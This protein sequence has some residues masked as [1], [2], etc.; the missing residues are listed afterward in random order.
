M[1]ITCEFTKN[2]TP[3]P[4]FSKNFTT[5]SEQQY[6]KMRLV[7][8]SE[9]K[10]ILEIFLN[11][12]FSKAA[13]KIYLF[14]KILTHFVHFLLWHH[15]KEEQ[16]FMIFFSKGFG[17]KCK[18]TELT[19]NF[20]QKQYFSEKKNTFPLHFSGVGTP[21]TRKK[22]LLKFYIFEGTMRP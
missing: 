20:N 15:F 16:V 6:W 22:L 2:C 8:A 14:Q 13:A 21:W 1:S 10:F 19:L 5:S 9:H 7:G 11:G 4:F 12:G 3:S 17:A 18:C